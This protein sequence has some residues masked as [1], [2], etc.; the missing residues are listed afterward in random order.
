MRLNRGQAATE[1]RTSAPTWKSGRDEFRLPERAQPNGLHQLQGDAYPACVHCVVCVGSMLL[2]SIGPL[3]TMRAGRGAVR[4]CG[5]LHALSLR[6]YFP[7]GQPGEQPQILRP[8]PRPVLSLVA[9]CLRPAFW[10]WLDD[11]DDDDIEAP[12]ACVCVRVQSEC[13]T[14]SDF[15]RQSLAVLDRLRPNRR[16]LF[17]RK[18]TYENRWPV[19]THRS[20]ENRQN[21][22]QK[23]PANCFRLEP[24]SC[25]NKYPK[26]QQSIQQRAGRRIRT[27]SARRLSRS[28]REIRCCDFGTHTH[29]D[30]QPL[31][32]R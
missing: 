17:T 9:F 18:K 16:A 23:S 6:A 26:P 25:T 19:S 10:G 1:Q 7:P 27:Q 5:R 11:D 32:R 28:G 30:I 14:V 29:V 24:N 22:R 8:T 13:V 2:D 15:R 4:L 21:R 31:C 12:M 20:G 3:I